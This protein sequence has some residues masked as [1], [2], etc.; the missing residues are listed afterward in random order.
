MKKQIIFL[1][2]IAT[3]AILNTAELNVSAG[4]TFPKMSNSEEA[5]DGTI[6]FNAGISMLSDTNKAI[7]FE[8][9]VRFKNMRFYYEESYSDDDF[10]YNAFT[11]VTTNFNYIDIFAKVKFNP[12]QSIE[13]NVKMFPFVGL[14]MGIF[15]NGNIKLNYDGEHIAYTTKLNLKDYVN[16]PILGISIGMDLLVNKAY[17]VGFEYNQALNSIIEDHTQRSNT[18][19]LNFGYLFTF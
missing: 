17:T 14:S 3:F 8:P 5:S 15:Q 9:G 7:I 16:S 2:C 13:T 6:G 10:G 1:I 11:S 4:L 18:I 19:L 12:L